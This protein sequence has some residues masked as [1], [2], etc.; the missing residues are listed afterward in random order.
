MDALQT[1]PVTI[2]AP[3]LGAGKSAYL[4]KLM[5]ILLE[6]CDRPSLSVSRL[7]KTAK[8]WSGIRDDLS[9]T[10]TWGFQISLPISSTWDCWH[11]WSAGPSLS[12]EL[13]G[14]SSSTETAPQSLDGWPSTGFVPY[15][16]P[17]SVPEWCRSVLRT[18]AARGQDVA[19]V[20]ATYNWPMPDA[21]GVLR[22]VD[23][24]V[25]RLYRMIGRRLVRKSQVLGPISAI[26]AMIAA[27]RRYGRRQDGDD[28]SNSLP[29]R[30]QTVSGR[31][32]SAS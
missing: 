12:V 19:D 26:L 6:D 18:G 2:A 4:T 23:G 5:W 21:A 10:G 8:Y 32:F 7:L 13:P 25:A 31:R 27:A 3:S 30:C 24:I 17:D 15:T 11:S 9:K 1:S 28:H 16:A 14:T 22:L 20:V 29:S